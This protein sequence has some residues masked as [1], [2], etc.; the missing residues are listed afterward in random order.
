MLEGIQGDNQNTALE[1]GFRSLFQ[2]VGVL[3]GSGVRVG[4]KDAG[5]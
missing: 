5:V 1:V 3:C 2:G 4:H